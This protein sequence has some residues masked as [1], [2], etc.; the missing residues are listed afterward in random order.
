MVTIW[1]ERNTASRSCGGGGL[2]PLPGQT[3]VVL[4]PE[5]SWIIDV[6]P[7]EDGH[8]QERSMFGEVLPMVK[9]GDLWIDDRNFCPT[10]LVF[11][12][13]RRGGGFLVRQHASTLH[14]EL[15]GKRHRRG[16]METGR[17]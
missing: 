2:R 13:A 6:L 9:P 4:D 12:V 16:R 1:R 10:G 8:A 17:V 14:W 7:C 11:G 5:W 15:V 3:L